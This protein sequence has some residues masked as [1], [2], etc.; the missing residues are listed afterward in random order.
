MSIQLKFTA[1]K[2]D[3]SAGINLQYIPARTHTKLEEETN[4]KQFF[5]T[6]SDAV[7]ESGKYIACL[8]QNILFS[9]PLLHI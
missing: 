4:I 2:P 8:V 5:D 6:Y 9:P 1:T 7:C 3:E